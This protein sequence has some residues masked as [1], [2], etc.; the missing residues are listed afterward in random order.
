MAEFNYKG[1]SVKECPGGLMLSGVSDFIPSHTFTC[2]QCFRWHEV[3]EESY[4]GVAGGHSARIS[5]LKDG[6]VE[7]LGVTGE[8][9]RGYW[10]N[11]LDLDTDYAAIKEAVADDGIMREAV[12][13]GSGIRLLRQEFGETVIS[14]IISANNNIPRIS[15]SVEKICNRWGEPVAGTDRRA[16]PELQVLAQVTETELRE[17]GV[18]F[19]D[20]YIKATAGALSC[21]ETADLVSLLRQ[22]T[23]GEAA[24]CLEKCPGI[25]PKVAHCILLFAG[26]RYDVFPKDVWVLRVMKQ[27][28]PGCSDTPADIDRAVQ[29]RFGGRAGYAQQYLFHYARNNL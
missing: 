23:C 26:I 10:Y 25:G 24:S 3:D 14:F 11:Y 6:A 27:L 19:R 18:G 17:T 12:H 21:A 4:H 22:G 8:E 15:G 2:G 28:Y 9:F 1:I 29:A 13:Y 5:M 7:L 16:F 20:K